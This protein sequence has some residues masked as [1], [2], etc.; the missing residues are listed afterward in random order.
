MSFVLTEEQ[1]A[2][3]DVMRSFV[4]EQ[5]A[6]YASEHDR[7]QT[8]PQESFDACVKMELP[9]MQIPAAYGGAGADMVTQAI[10]IEQLA[11]GCASTSVTILISKLAMLPIMNFAS[12]EIKQAYLPRIA[13]GEIQGSYCLSE[14]DAGSDVASMRCRAVRDGDDY[15]LNGSKYWI[16]N[17]GVSDIYTVFATT[18]PTARTHGITCFLVEK[19]PGVEFPK[20]EDK[21]GLRGSPTGEVVFT[22]VRVPASHRIGNEGE[23]FLMAMHTLDR[24]RP[25]IGAQA[26]GIA[27]AAI[28]FAGNYM[29]GRKAFGRPIADLQGLRF[30]LADM[31]IRTEAARALVYQACATIDAGDPDGNLSYLG[32][33]AKAFASDTAMSVTTDAV[34]LLGGYGFTKEFPVERFMRDAKITQ[35]YEGT[36]Q[37]Q[38][39]VIAKHLLK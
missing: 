35:I 4:D 14:A 19:G 11:R 3:R 25:T 9:S 7:D 21:M 39:V 33:A 22:D 2:F 12:E 6:P 10:M 27:Q 16:T 34:Q 30:M 29:K 28:D 37:I 1:R 23:G 26:V 17:A 38:R 31:A 36:N 13:S 8:Y 5:V 18:D 15:V 20:H 32:A 24:S